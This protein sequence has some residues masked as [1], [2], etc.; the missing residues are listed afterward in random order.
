MSDQKA[1]ATARA[2]EIQQEVIDGL[3][4]LQG[5]ER[6]HAEKIVLFIVVGLIPHVKI[7]Y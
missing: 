6:H 5:I 7:E 2:I 4:N 3:A 1:K